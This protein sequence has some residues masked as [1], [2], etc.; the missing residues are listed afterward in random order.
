MHICMRT[1]WSWFDVKRMSLNDRKKVLVMIDEHTK[2]KNEKNQKS[3]A[4]T[5]ARAAAG[6]RW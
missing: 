5:A 3:E 4:K 1:G 2:M 6:R